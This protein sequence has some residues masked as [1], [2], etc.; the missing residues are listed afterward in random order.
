[1]TRLN[2]PRSPRTLDR[3][4]LAAGLLTMTTLV[5]PFRPP[6]SPTCRCLLLDRASRGRFRARQERFIRLTMPRRP[7]TPVLL[8]ILSVR[9]VA[10][11]SNLITPPFPQA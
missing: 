11:F 7:S 3:R 9:E 8:N 5:P 1:M 2:S 4:R 10:K 6:V